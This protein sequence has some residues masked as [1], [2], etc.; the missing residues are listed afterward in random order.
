MS[1]IKPTLW[2]AGNELKLA[3]DILGK[4]R[5]LFVAIAKLNGDDAVGL[6]RVGQGLAEE[7]EDNFGDMADQFF[8]EHKT[9]KEQ[10]GGAQ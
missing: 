9:Q 7:W 5:A 4:T 10:L 1:A 2:S 3:A 8:L 6:A